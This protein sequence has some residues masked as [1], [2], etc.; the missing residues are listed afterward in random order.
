MKQ[1]RTNKKKRHLPTIEIYM[2]RDYNSEIIITKLKE[3]RKFYLMNSDHM[4]ELD[5]LP[6]GF[7]STHQLI[8]K[9]SF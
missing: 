1:R 5:N 2:S 4:D 3:V 8:Y 9:T 7:E 6:D